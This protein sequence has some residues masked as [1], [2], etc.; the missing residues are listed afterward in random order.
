MTPFLRIERPPADAE[1]PIARTMSQ[2]LIPGREHEQITAWALLVPLD[3]S[4]Q[5]VSAES[6]REVP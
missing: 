3:A 5:V 4:W 6:L 2:A 1:Q